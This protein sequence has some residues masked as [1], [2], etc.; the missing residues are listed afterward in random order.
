MVKWINGFECKND[1]I[2]DRIDGELTL[3][4]L[5]NK[6]E[7][8]SELVKNNYEKRTINKLEQDKIDLIFAA[9]IDYFEE[10]FFITYDYRIR[11]LYDYLK[12]SDPS[13]WFL[14]DFIGYCK[15]NYD[16]T[17][18]SLGDH[19][20][21]IERVYEKESGRRYVNLY[22]ILFKHGE[23]KIKPLICRL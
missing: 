19:P 11:T 18:K 5:H 23:L 7:T 14:V 15:L 16:F 6:V 21:I 10:L 9:L 13:A 22:D 1:F 3:K 8:A 12:M 17:E 4:N 2:Y 20:E